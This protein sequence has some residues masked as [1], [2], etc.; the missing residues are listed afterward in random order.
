MENTLKLEHICAINEKAEDAKVRKEIEARKVL[1]KERHKKHT[2]ETITAIAVSVCLLVVVIGVFIKALTAPNAYYKRTTEM[3][4]DGNYFVWV[5]ERICE[6]E[7]I[8]DDLITVEYKGNL[9]DFFVCDSDTYEV[10]EKI[11]CQFTN[12]WEIV[13]ISDWDVN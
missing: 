4:P 5:T 6:I 8:E 2:R 11:V 7:E 13:G 9:Y 1:R 3:Q 10:G 12:D